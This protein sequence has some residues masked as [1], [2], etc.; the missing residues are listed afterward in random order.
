MEGNNSLIR[1]AVD[2]IHEFQPGIHRPE[3]AAASQYY[4]RNADDTIAVSSVSAQDLAVDLPHLEF[5]ALD[6]RTSIF[7]GFD[8][9]ET[10]SG[11]VVKSQRLKVIGIDY[12]SLTSCLLVDH[13]AG[14]GLRL[15]DD[16]RA[17]NS[18]D[19]D[20]TILVRP[21]DPV[22]RQLTALVRHTSLPSA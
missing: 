7:I 11:S 22:G 6:S 20:L 8:D 14:D 16:L 21:V 5:D 3:L 17:N 13:I 1:I 12:D 19:Q 9:L 10:A 4:E 2:G 15:R 18:A